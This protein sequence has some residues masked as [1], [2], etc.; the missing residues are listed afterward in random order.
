MRSASTS[1]LTV[2]ALSALVNLYADNPLSP[3]MTC[4]AALSEASVSS[5]FVW[6]FFF[7]SLS[8]GSLPN[9]PNCPRI[10]THSVDD[11]ELCYQK[12]K[13]YPISL[14]D[15]YT[16]PFMIHMCDECLKYYY[17]SYDYHD[18]QKFIKSFAQQIIDMPELPQKFVNNFL[19]AM[20]SC[21]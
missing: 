15:N 11:Y 16:D 18:C 4:D 13:G 8:A 3:H 9:A 6:Y 19:S 17:S 12:L 1:L 7:L 21:S 20:L 10:Y 5:T 14:A 2:L